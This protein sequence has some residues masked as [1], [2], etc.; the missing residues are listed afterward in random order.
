LVLGYL[1][2][3]TFEPKFNWREAVID[4]TT[5]PIVIRSLDWKQARIHPTIAG[6]M[7]EQE[8]EAIVEELETLTAVRSISTKLAIEAEQYTEAV[9][10]LPIYQRHAR[11]FSEEE[12]HRFPPSRTWDHAIN[13]K[14]G[15]PNSLNCK[16]YPTTP[17]EKVALKE[18]IGEMEEKKYIHRCDPNKAYIMSSF[19]FINKKDGKRRPVQ[20]YRAVNKMTERDLYPLHLIPTV[21]AEVGNASIFTKFDICWGYNNVQIKE[22]NQHKAAF[23]TEFGLFEPMVMFFG[24]TNSPATFQCMMDTI[25]APLKAKHVLLGTSIQVYMDD[26][27]IAS[28]SGM[29]GHRAAVHDVLDLLAEHDLFLKLEKCK[30]ETDS[31]DYLG[32]ILEKGVTCMDPTKVSGIRDW[33]TPTSIKQVC[34]FLGFCNFYH[35]FIRRFSKLARPLNQLTRKDTPWTWGPEENTAFEDLRTRVTT[36][37]ILVQPQVDKLFEL[38][39]DASGFATG[40]ILMQKGEDNKKHPVG[41]YSVTLNDAEQNYDI[42]DLELLAVVNALE[43]WQH[44]LAGSPHKVI[45]YTDHLNLQYW[46]EPHKISRQVARQVL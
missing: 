5:L 38:E 11:V 27:L 41:Y 12:S 15:S 42:Y 37:P 1:W 18:W 21:I 43:H 24:L 29:D 2:L 20:D 30:W 35:S 4:T 31:I 7:T 17:V 13:L 34:S 23:K 45:V 14:A 32:L 39:V 33:L 44:F 22:G 40:A 3:A 46:W 9:A 25:F 28:S 10:I 26:I 19:F 8:K 36:E 16:I 6:I